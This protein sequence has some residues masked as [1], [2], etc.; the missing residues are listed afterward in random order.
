MSGE[1]S[2]VNAALCVMKNNNLAC[3]VILRSMQHQLP[4]ASC[5]ALQATCNCG[6]PGLAASTGVKYSDCTLTGGGTALRA[7]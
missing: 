4:A 6:A 5:I 7:D 3:N 2:L 1:Q